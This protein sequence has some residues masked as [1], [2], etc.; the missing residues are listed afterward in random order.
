MTSAEVEPLWELLLGK[1]PGELRAEFM[2][3]NQAVVKV[4]RAGGSQKLM[5]LPRTHRIDASAVA[6]QF[7]RGTVDLVYTPT[8][9]QAA[10]IGTKRFEQPPSWVKVL[11]L[12]QIVTPTFWTAED[13][14]TYQ[15]SLFEP[16]TGLP[17]KP[18]GF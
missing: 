8:Q 11:Y 5:H 4:C 3:D 17:V 13:Y 18:G 1:R 2:E 7:A 14:K 15:S 16:G 6:E 9:D 12:V 10:D